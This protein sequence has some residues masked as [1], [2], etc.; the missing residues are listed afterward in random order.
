MH[1]MTAGMHHPVVHG[2]IWRFV[3]LLDRQG[4]HIRPQQ[5]G[6]A[7]GSAAENANYAFAEMGADTLLHL[8]AP[9]LQ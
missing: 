1:I 9:F 2:L 3:L 8:K 7:R 5:H 4:I 6:F